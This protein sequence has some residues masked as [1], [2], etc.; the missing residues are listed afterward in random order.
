MKKVFR[1]LASFAASLAICL[2][3]FSPALTVPASAGTS[4][5]VTGKINSYLDTAGTKGFGYKTSEAPTTGVVIG[6]IVTTVLSFTGLIAFIIFLYGGYLWLTARGNDDQV[7]EAKKY[8]TNGSLGVV[9][10][11]LAWSA[12]YFI[13][14]SL[15]RSAR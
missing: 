5:T 10:I 3:V 13:T 1:F 15:Y 4:D 14:L 9:I 11:I 6:R 12:S 8:L 7:A 2:V